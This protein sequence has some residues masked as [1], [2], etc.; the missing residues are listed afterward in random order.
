M[1]MV[2]VVFCYFFLARGMD[3][4]GWFF[5]YLVKYGYLVYG[6]MDVCMYVRDR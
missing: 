4:V 3:L 1:M 5:V 2:V 6:W